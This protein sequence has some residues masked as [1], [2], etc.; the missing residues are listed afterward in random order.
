M[1][2]VRAVGTLSVTREFSIITQGVANGTLS[3]GN[4]SGSASAVQSMQWLYRLYYDLRTSPPTQSHPYRIAELWPKT[5]A[6][7]CFCNARHV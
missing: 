4:T 1:K 5:R 6:N 3:R 7:R 2:T